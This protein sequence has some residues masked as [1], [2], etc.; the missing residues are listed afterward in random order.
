MSIMYL[1]VYCIYSHAYCFYARLGK[2]NRCGADQALSL[3]MMYGRKSTSL[4]IFLMV[5][6]ALSLYF[7]H[8]CY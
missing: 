5:Y 7:Y 2:F 4:V 1:L 8:K 3:C 6:I